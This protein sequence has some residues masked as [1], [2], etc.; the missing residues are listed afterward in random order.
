M[1]HQIVA[2]LPG[3]ATGAGHNSFDIAT[4]P[5]DK[6]SHLIYAFAGFRKAGN[7]W[8]ADYPEPLDADPA[9]P[10]SNV[11][12]LI[13]LKQRWPALR[14]LVSVGGSSNSHQ[15]DP[16]QKTTPIFSALAAT[17]AARQAFVSS[18]IE[19]FITR[20]YPGVGK[21]FDGIDIDWE[22]PAASDRGNATL[23]LRE[24][25]RQLDQTGVAE[26]RQLFL[27]IAA[28]M[29][30]QEFELDSLATTLDW[31]N[32]MAYDAHLPN[33]NPKN[34]LTDFGSPLYRDPA[35]P[36]SNVTWNIDATVKA[37]L[38]AGLPPER[39]V[40]GISAYGR[41]YADV[42]TADHGVYQ[43]YNGA[44]PGS[45]G[46]PGVL[47]YRDIVAGYLPEYELLWH[48][49]TRSAYLFNPTQRVWISFEDARSVAEKSR[50]ADQ[51]KLGGLMLWEISADTA[52][53]S[54]A[55]SLVG[56]M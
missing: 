33:D 2:Y 32:L 31:V 49:P 23:L 39:L 55:P 53:G 22:S 3:Y 5:G 14:V 52:P 43:T 12:K 44:G 19:L 54:S 45:F 51:M 29:R 24:F 17:A 46:Q 10:H 56:Q 42:V 28:E 13:A 11:G 6:I 1:T 30:A 15:G 37:F 36:G 48:Q 35:E 4:I 26:K 25:R 9:N 27:T 7:G 34:R 8:V 18:C 47:S 41:S 16:S 21:L 40:L 50:Y 20:T 38:A